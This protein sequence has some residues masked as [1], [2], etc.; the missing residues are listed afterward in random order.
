MRIKPLVMT[1]SMKKLSLIV[2]LPVVFVKAKSDVI[3]ALSK[4][5]EGLC[6]WSSLLKSLWSTVGLRHF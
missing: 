1:L 6:N 3:W 2:I 4:S 5:A